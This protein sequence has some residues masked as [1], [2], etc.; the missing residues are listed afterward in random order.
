MT[1]EARTYAVT[2]YGSGRTTATVTIAS[3]DRPERVRLRLTA[4][5]EPQVELIRLGHGEHVVIERVGV[6]ETHRRTDGDDHDP[7]AVHLVVDGDVDGRGRRRGTRSLE[8]DHGRAEV[9]RRLVALLQ[10]GDPAAD[11]HTHGLTAERGEGGKTGQ[12]EHNH[13][14]HRH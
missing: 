8:V 5:V 4:T 9:G 3:F 7:R 2:G 12:G 11:L 14:A 10:N 6:G 13:P 1:S